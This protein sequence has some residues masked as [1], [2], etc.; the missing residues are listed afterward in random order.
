M[1][2]DFEMIGIVNPEWGHH[3]MIDFPVE[4]GIGTRLKIIFDFFLK[5]S[6]KFQIIPKVSKFGKVRENIFKTNKSRRTIKHNLLCAM[7][8]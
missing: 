5:Y 4:V 1:S 8:A 2:I 6:K 3:V 7:P